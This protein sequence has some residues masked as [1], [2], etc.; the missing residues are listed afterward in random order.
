M[1]IPDRK[2]YN[3]KSAKCF[4]CF[5]LDTL[6]FCLYYFVCYKRVSLS[7][8]HLGA[9][10][11]I[12]RQDTFD[13]ILLLLMRISFGLISKRIKFQGKRREHKPPCK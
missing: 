7:V 5:D 3:D 4:G 1:G 11:L 9:K 2:T 10:S 12:N 13:A 6:L 8:L